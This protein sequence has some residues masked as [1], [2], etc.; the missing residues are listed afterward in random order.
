MLFKVTQK[1]PNLYC[2]F[3]KQISCQKT[4]INFPIWSHWNH[5]QIFG[6][7][8]IK[9]QELYRFVLRLEEFRIVSSAP[10]PPTTIHCTQQVLNEQC[11]QIWQKLSPLA[12]NVKFEAILQGVM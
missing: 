4:L 10:P 7:E 6:T 11:D 2:Y 5:N 12:K 9:C 1:S 8:K 3:C